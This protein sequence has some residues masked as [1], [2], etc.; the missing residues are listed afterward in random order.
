MP[1]S[2]VQPKRKTPIYYLGNKQSISREILNAISDVAIGSGPAIDLF[3]GTG[4]VSRAISRYRNVIAVDVQEYSRILCSAFIEK[5]PNNANCID[6]LL[7]RS[8]ARYRK[9]AEVYKPLLCLERASTEKAQSHDFEMLAEIIEH[10]CLLSQYRSK[11]PTWLL[12]ASDAVKEGRVNSSIEDDEDMIARYFG[13]TYFS[14]EQA[15]RL[16]SLRACCSDTSDETEVLAAILST[17]SLSASTIGGQLAQPVKAF[18][19]YGKIKARTLQK[20][21]R[22]RNTEIFPTFEKAFHELNILAVPRDDNLAVKEECINFLNNYNS[23][24]PSIV[25][26]DPPYSRY[27]YSRYYH[28]LETIAMNDSPQISINPATKQASRGIYREERY[29]SSFSTKGKAHKAFEDLFK[30]VANVTPAFVLSYSPYLDSVDTTPRMAK[31]DELM[32]LAKESFTRVSCKTLVG[33]T[34]SKLANSRDALV[35]VK[36]AEVL[37]ICQN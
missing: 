15:L 20:V 1:K 29:Q 4:A 8:E 37:V 12:E 7:E 22:I 34:H 23:K 28:V 6:E 14:Y 9:L 10:G 35:T 2:G 19:K 21:L 18:D 16:S 32:E 31:I 24:D 33:T 36:D 27:H 11:K 13:G 5:H 25:Y 3:A 17:A 26:A 30:A